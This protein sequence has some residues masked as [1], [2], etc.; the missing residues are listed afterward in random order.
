MI[1]DTFSLSGQTAVITGA[2]RGI[3]QVIASALAQAGADIVACDVDGASAEAT[4]EAIRSDGRKALGVQVD[5]T[6]EISVAGL[7][8]Q[9][10][11]WSGRLDVLVNNAGVT[12]Q[13]EAVALTLDEWNRVLGVNL[14]GVFLCCRCAAPVM[15]RGGGGRI[16][17]VASINGQ[18][19]PAFHPSSAYS[20][21]K[22]GVLGL[23]RALAVEWGKSGI[24]VNAICP[25][26]VRTDM[27]EHRLSDPEYLSNIVGRTPLGRVAEPLDMVGA[28]LFLASFASG[29]VTGHAL[30]VDGGWVIV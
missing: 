5:V 11:D 18:V 26:Y 17:N 25:T 15:V 12:V 8:E 27:T 3:G 2:G 20:A 7:V 4:A 6:Q 28:A 29:M 10:L 22:A 14:T 13:K 24:R 30:N 1:L 21:A 9:A 16:V 19:A 23:T